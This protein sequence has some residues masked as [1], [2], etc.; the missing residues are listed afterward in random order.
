MCVCTKQVMYKA[1]SH[2]QPTYAHKSL[3]CNC[4]PANCP[5]FYG[6]PHDVIIVLN[7]L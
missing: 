5:Q 4:L 3:S 1:I 6:F 2:H 7:V